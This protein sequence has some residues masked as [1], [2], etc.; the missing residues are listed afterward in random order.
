MTNIAEQHF[1]GGGGVLCVP[2]PVPRTRLTAHD[3]DPGATP[4]KCPRIRADLQSL[5]QP[6]PYCPLLSP[7]ACCCGSGAHDVRVPG[8][9]SIRPPGPIPCDNKYTISGCEAGI[10]V[11][12]GSV[13]T[14]SLAIEDSTLSGNPPGIAGV[15]VGLLVQAGTLSISDSTLNWLH[16][17]RRARDRRIRIGRVQQTITDNGGGLIDENG[18]LTVAGSILADNQA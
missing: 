9:A 13:G 1:G 7:S 3:R 15:G 18:P 10:E 14:P 17:P 11:A 12:A 4:G 8:G 16:N 2:A 6:V 5:S